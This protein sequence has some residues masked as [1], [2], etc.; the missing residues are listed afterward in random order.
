MCVLI[1][2]GMAWMRRWSAYTLWMDDLSKWVSRRKIPLHSLNTFHSGF[3]WNKF[4]VKSIPEISFYTVVKTLVSIQA[5]L[6]VVYTELQ[7]NVSCRTLIS[8]SSICWQSACIWT[9][10]QNAFT[11]GRIHFCLH[12]SGWDSTD[13]RSQEIHRHKK[14]E[15]GTKPVLLYSEHVGNV[16]SLHLWMMQC[17]R[18]VAAYLSHELVCSGASQKERTT[19]HLRRLNLY[20]ALHAGIWDRKHALSECFLGAMSMP[21]VEVKKCR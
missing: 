7:Q 2:L 8:H 4:G 14:R 16:L 6:S 18:E 17:L 19:L 12:L 3:T 5:V 10:Q 1:P 15:C 9:N 21:L 13:V 20:S 11:Q